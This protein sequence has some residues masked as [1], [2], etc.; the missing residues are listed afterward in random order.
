VNFFHREICND[1][2]INEDVISIMEINISVQ[3]T[4]ETIGG[5]PFS[6]T[7]SIYITFIAIQIL[8]HEYRKITKLN[9]N[10]NF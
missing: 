3:F 5:K 8:K 2:V 6:K 9:R 1:G 10:L 7:H 4:V